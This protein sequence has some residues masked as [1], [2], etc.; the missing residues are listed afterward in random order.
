[1]EPSSKSAAKTWWW[2][3]ESRQ[4]LGTEMEHI[5][6]IAR[7]ENQATVANFDPEL[8]INILTRYQVTSPAE[9]KIPSDF[10][11]PEDDSVPFF[12]THSAGVGGCFSE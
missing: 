1:M 9:F 5:G 2:S 3:D 6:G 7:L 12:V 4:E 10:A 11:F 8:S